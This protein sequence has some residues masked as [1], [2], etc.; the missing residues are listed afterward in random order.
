MLTRV[1]DAIDDRLAVS[2]AIAARV[3]PGMDNKRKEGMSGGRERS[4]S[5]AV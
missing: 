5:Q 3:L 1:A 4:K 2:E